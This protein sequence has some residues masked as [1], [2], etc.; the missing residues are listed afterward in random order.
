MCA[1]VSPP[2]S[3]EKTTLK[4]IVRATVSTVTKADPVA[5]EEFAGFSF[6][7]LNGPPNV[8]IE[9]CADHDSKVAPNMMRVLM[10]ASSTVESMQDSIK[11]QSPPRLANRCPGTLAHSLA[12]SLC[13]SH[14]GCFEPV[15]ARTLLPPMTKGSRLRECGLSERVPS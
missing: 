13:D 2:V 14:I 3:P 12:L 6:V 5:A 10:N 4:F 11:V 8:T 1:A 7:A 15:S 9:A